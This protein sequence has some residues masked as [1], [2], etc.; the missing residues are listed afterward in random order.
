MPFLRRRFAPEP[1]DDDRVLFASTSLLEATLRASAITIRGLVWDA[2]TVPEPRDDGRAYAHVVLSGLLATDVGVFGPGEAA[3][4]PSFAALHRAGAVAL[5]EPHRAVALRLDGGE[6]SP[7][8]AS[9][10]IDAIARSYT[11][12]RDE[13][14]SA[15]AEATSL[16]RSL[17]LETMAE[18]RAVEDDARVAEALSRVLSGPSGLPSML[19]LGM[20]VS[21]RHSRRRIT[22][23]FRSF[24]MP[25]ETFREMRLSYTLTTAMLYLARP[26]VSVERCAR[27]VGLSSATS[28]CH[29]IAK[30]ELPPPRVARERR[31][32]A[33]AA[34][35]K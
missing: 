32:R 30:A 33:L 35:P 24:R 22:S 10:S 19:D 14:P 7:R 31:A 17:G 1:A 15:H 20:P 6:V 12:I 2:T 16:A 34:W 28:L 21:S 3:I 27:A 25:F 13:G 8:R 5:G 11:S 23:F 26:D 18:A 4:F 29:A 9:C